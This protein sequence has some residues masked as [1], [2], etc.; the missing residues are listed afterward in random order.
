[1]LKERSRRRGL[2][3]GQVSPIVLT[4][5]NVSLAND[6]G[7][8]FGAKRNCRCVGAEAHLIPE[9][10]AH[11]PADCCAVRQ[12]TPANNGGSPWHT[13]RNARGTSPT[14]YD[15]LRRNSWVE[16][17]CKLCPGDITNSVVIHHQLN[18]RGYAPTRR[19]RR[20]HWRFTYVETMQRN[21]KITFYVMSAVGSHI[22]TTNLAACVCLCVCAQ[23]FTNFCPTLLFR[24][25]TS[26]KFCSHSKIPI[27]CLWTAFCVPLFFIFYEKQWFI[28]QIVTLS[29]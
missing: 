25:Q 13:L 18:S 24:L 29:P 8:S 10:L 17:S 14:G 16:L 23:N 3:R 1:M 15:A 12:S 6:G 4:I 7:S 20:I 28:T 22:L 21:Q 9:V 26:R 5:I 19:R 27:R 2:R 11:T